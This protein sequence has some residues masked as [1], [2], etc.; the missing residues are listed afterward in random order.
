MSLD[1]ARIIRLHAGREN[2][3]N[4]ALSSIRMFCQWAIDQDYL[5]ANLPSGS[6]RSEDKLCSLLSPCLLCFDQGEFFRPS[7]LNELGKLFDV[8]YIATQS[9]AT[10]P[11]AN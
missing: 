11:L 4:R 5:G 1:A 6:S 2:F 7:L 10:R 9:M 3:I 8:G